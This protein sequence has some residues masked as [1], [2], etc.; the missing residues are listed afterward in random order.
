MALVSLKQA[1]DHLRLDLDLTGGITLDSSIDELT[2]KIAQATAII[3]DYLKKSSESPP[4]APALKD[5][6]VV[7][8]ATLLT[9][10]A[11][12]DDR[13]GTGDGD[14]L[15]ENGAIARLLRRMRDPTMA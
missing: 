6:P 4:W 5:Q 14:Y 9:L 11:L 8:A 3:V 7:Q 12:W 15:S 13:N 10:S 2:L 1:S